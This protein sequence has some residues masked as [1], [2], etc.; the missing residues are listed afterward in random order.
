MISSARASYWLD[1]LPAEAP[2]PCD[3][4]VEFVTGLSAFEA[5]EEAL[6]T[7]TG[8]SYIRWYVFHA[9]VPAPKGIGSWL[10][11]SDKAHTYFHTQVP[12][13]PFWENDRRF[14]LTWPAAVEIYAELCKH[15]PGYMMTA[16]THWPEYRPDMLA[17]L[18][19]IRQT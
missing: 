15:D 14:V 4:A 9:K 5:L 10:T 7:P 8:C 17:T 16:E 3:A 11:W 2:D 19:K 12:Y 18:H 13:T 6:K 1:R